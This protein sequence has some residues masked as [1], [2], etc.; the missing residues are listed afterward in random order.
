VRCVRN[1]ALDV[2]RL[3]YAISVI[4]PKTARSRRVAERF[5][6]RALGIP[7]TPR[8]FGHPVRFLVS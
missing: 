6:V 5:G 3:T 1:Y 4:L 2:V 8:A 7:E